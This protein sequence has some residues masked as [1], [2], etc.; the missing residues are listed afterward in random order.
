M[1][2]RF[3]AGTGQIILASV[4][5]C[6]IMLWFVSLYRSMYQELVGGAPAHAHN[7]YGKYGALLFL[8]SWIWSWVTSLSLLR[9]AK[10]NT[11][12]LV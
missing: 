12:P 3:I 11:P 7:E 9:E 1:G 8:A 6:L 4:G 2:R 5:F 10:R